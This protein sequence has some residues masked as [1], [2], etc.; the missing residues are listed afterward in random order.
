MG[1]RIL[2]IVFPQHAL[3]VDS[4]KP[5]TDLSTMRSNSSSALDMDGPVK[6]D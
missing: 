3:R 6:V 1:V 4:T 5:P 2:A